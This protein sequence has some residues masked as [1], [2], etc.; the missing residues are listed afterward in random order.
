[1]PAPKKPAAPRTT[2]KVKGKPK[3]YHHGN[4]REALLEAGLELLRR[5]SAESLGLRELA[6]QAGVSRTAP[7]RH[8]ES[9]EALIAAIAEQGFLRLQA[10]QD[11]AKRRYPDDVEAWFLEGARQ[12][13]R[14]A[15]DHPEHLKVMFG[16]YISHTPGHTDHPVYAV[17]NA[18]FGKLVEL[19]ETA[20][21]IGLVRAG[22]PVEVSVSVW[23][24]LHGFA[25]LMVQKQFDFLQLGPGRLAALAE[26]AAQDTLSAV[27][28]PPSGSGRR[29]RATSSAP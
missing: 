10:Y 8:F 14:F 6:R 17:G 12:Y 21:R 15:V 13:I 25:M 29:S 26:Q 1:M 16:P 5:D 11:E 4:L 27:R 23:S 9:K 19:V 3:S 22:D 20:Q 7:Y 28:A 24:M 2:D 18:T